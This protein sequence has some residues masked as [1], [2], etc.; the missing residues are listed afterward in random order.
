MERLHIDRV[1][2]M[3]MIELSTLLEWID[4]DMRRRRTHRHTLGSLPGLAEEARL[5][6]MKRMRRARR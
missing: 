2:T 4:R 6:R 3:T 1:E 5:E